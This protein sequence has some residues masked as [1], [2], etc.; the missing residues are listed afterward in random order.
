MWSAKR[1]LRQLCK[2]TGHACTAYSFSPGG[3]RIVSTSY[4]Y[5]VT[6]WDAEPETEVENLVREGVLV[7]RVGHLVVFFSH[8]SKMG[9]GSGVRKGWAG[10]C[11]RWWDTR[12]LCASLPSPWTGRAS[13]G[14]AS[15][16]QPF[17]GLPH[18]EDLC[19]T[20]R[21]QSCG[22]LAREGRSKTPRLG[23][24]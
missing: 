3:K 14:S 7:L 5:P 10:K 24:L 11:T 22:G 4:D 2:L 16:R 1:V 15:R 23:L 17:Q 8:L 12:A 6:I 19:S 21:A 20:G 13:S 18:S 9:V